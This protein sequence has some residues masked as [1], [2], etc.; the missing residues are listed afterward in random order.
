[1][2]RFSATDSATGVWGVSDAGVVSAPA[3]QWN[4]IAVVRNGSSFNV[5]VNG[6]AGTAVTFAGTIQSSTSSLISGVYASTLGSVNGY[7]DE[8]RVTKGIARYTANFTPP[9]A[10]FANAQY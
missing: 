3:G 7:I 4:H 10:P 1:V 9:T 8:L 2:I 6:A 5:Y